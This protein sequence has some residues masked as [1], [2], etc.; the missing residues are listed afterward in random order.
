MVREPRSVSAKV[1]HRM[2]LSTPKGMACGVVE[3]K[4]RAREN[5]TLINATGAHIKES[6]A[7]KKQ[8]R[9]GRLRK[10]VGWEGK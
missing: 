1:F 10:Y 2:S 6:V 4:L 8:K 9:S 7:F 3:R 5:A